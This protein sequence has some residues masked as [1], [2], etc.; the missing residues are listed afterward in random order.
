[1]AVTI[2]DETIVVD[3]A[4]EA[5][6][7]SLEVTFNRLDFVTADTGFES[8]ATLTPN[9]SEPPTGSVYWEAVSIANPSANWWNRGPGYEGLWWGAAVPEGTDWDTLTYA[10]AEHIGNN[11]PTG[12]TAQLTDVVGERTVVIRATVTMTGESREMTVTFGR[13]PMSIFSRL[14]MTAYS[15]AT[16]ATLGMLTL[17]QSGFPMA[18]NCGWVVPNTAADLGVDASGIVFNSGNWIEN[19][20]SGTKVGYAPSA[21]VASMK[22]LAAVAIKGPMSEFPTVPGKGAAIAAGM[23]G[24]WSSGD[25]SWDPGISRFRRHDIWLN[26]ATQSDIMVN[27]LSYGTLCLK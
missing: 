19:S 3:L 21:K 1:M 18:Q 6:S 14:E 20:V 25:I 22:Q 24:Y 4:E 15:Y 16:N 27:S 12:P 11:W 2:G 9:F 8:T 26:G 23:G 10:R 17:P 5:G 7:S 13:G